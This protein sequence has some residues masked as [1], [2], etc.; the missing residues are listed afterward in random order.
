M[1]EEVDDGF[2]FNSGNQL[3]S[4]FEHNGDLYY[5]YKGKVVKL[6]GP[7]DPPED[8]ASSWIEDPSFIEKH[9]LPVHYNSFRP[10]I[11]GKSHNTD[12]ANDE[13]VYSSPKVRSGIVHVYK[14]K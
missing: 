12:E 13:R 1:Y 5:N 14:P 6:P 2:S 9:K 8:N 7:N 3:G 4:I 10:N 11:E